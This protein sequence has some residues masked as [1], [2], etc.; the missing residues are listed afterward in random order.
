M[1]FTLTTFFLL[2][3]VCFLLG[4]IVSLWGS[5][6]GGLYVPL[7][8]LG[9]GIDPQSAV[10]TSLVTILAV[11]FVS[12]AS[13]HREGNLNIK[14]GLIFGIGG[15]A[16]GLFGAYLSSQIPSVNL[17]KILGFFLIAMGILMAYAGRGRMGKSIQ[18]ELTKSIPRLGIRSS[19]VGIIFGSM[20]GFMTGLVGSSG[21]PPTMAG[22]YIIGFPVA[23]V[24]G[25]SVFVTIFS[26]FAGLIGHVW[27]GQFNLSLTLL[28]VAGASTGAFIGPLVLNK[29]KGRILERVYG[30]AFVIAMVVMGIVLLL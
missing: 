17:E 4:L 27:F 23:T 1:S 6:G 3:I 20:S 21:T 9:F 7:L 18:T 11:T 13:H 30:P 5:G 12:S 28:L 19:L 10:A 26:A 8:I 16:G 15:L 2:P 22:L 25:T 24:I 14:A 29:I